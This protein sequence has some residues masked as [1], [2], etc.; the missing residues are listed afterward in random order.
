[1]LYLLAHLKIL[2]N[3]KLSRSGKPNQ[4]QCHPHVGLHLPG[5]LSRHPSFPLFILCLWTWDLLVLIKE[6]WLPRFGSTYGGQSFCFPDAEIHSWPTVPCLNWL[7]CPRDSL[8]MATKG[9]LRE[10]NLVH[11][12]IPLS[13][14]I[15]YLLT[16]LVLGTTG[17]V[18]IVGASAI[19]LALCCPLLTLASLLRSPFL[20]WHHWPQKDV[21]DT[22]SPN[23][24][25]CFLIE[26][27]Y[28]L[29]TFHID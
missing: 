18:L 5:D 20:P 17:G 4:F 24:A 11:T 8:S 23:N 29:V 22:I 9:C 7:S 21:L 14:C 12:S 2:E 13:S 1:M 6:N 16:P 15:P 25:I 27:I 26:Y 3:S 28:R 10:Y 19:C